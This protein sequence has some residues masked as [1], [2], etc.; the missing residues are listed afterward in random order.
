[1]VGSLSEWGILWPTVRGAA[2]V[3][4]V[5][6][7]LGC[8]GSDAAK[9][10]GDELKLTGTLAEGVLS[11]GVRMGVRAGQSGG[12][13]A[14]QEEGVRAS[15][16]RRAG[17][18]GG[19]L[20]G[21]AL[22]CVTFEETPRAGK[23]VTDA[24]SR[25]VLSLAAAQVPFGCFVLD[26]AGERVADLIFKVGSAE[27]LA[28]GVSLDRDA[29][30]GTVIVDR[31]AYAAV[32]D[33]SRLS[34]VVVSSVKQAEAEDPNFDFTGTWEETECKWW[35]GTAIEDCP[36]RLMEIGGKLIYLHR[37]VIRDSASDRRRYLFGVWTSEGLFEGCG[38]TEGLSEKILAGL[39]AALQV[40][41][42][43]LEKAFAFAPEPPASGNWEDFLGVCE[44]AGPG[45]ERRTCMSLT[46]AAEQAVCY[47]ACIGALEE[48]PPDVCIR[49]RTVDT[50]YLNRFIRGE[51]GV[52]FNLSATAEK[53]GFF[54][55]LD[56]PMGR[57]TLTEVIYHSPLS[58]SG[59]SVV[60]IPVPYW[61]DETQASRT[62]IETLT[63]SVTDVFDPS[64]PTLSEDNVLNVG[65]SASSPDYA[66]CLQNAGK[67]YLASLHGT[68]HL[69]TKGRRIK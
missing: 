40:G 1:M 42:E 36:P 41:Q 29:D 59:A 10:E 64:G 26:G 66:W 16:L 45:G 14:G 27:A 34:Q 68:L 58:M 31:A 61:D 49:E 50:A 46:G 52:A 62:C 11:D 28:G 63:F 20:S 32:A 43:S 57:R 5:A 55:T 3:L 30:L 7:M 23:G 25:F 22:Y 18:S 15:G 9:G 17:A 47:S 4:A 51:E 54:V 12:V 2:G 24:S 13:R 8:T 21:Y 39:G 53:P 69:R 67:L 37:A 65:I 35:K 48:D 56:E 6:C 60:E 44:S 38:S 19:S 33:L